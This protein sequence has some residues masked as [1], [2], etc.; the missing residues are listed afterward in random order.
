MLP[1]IALGPSKF[2]R[3][4][5]ANFP[6]LGYTLCTVQSVRGKGE[7]DRKTREVGGISFCAGKTL[8]A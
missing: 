2:H 6:V 5:D 8:A 4:A 3:L 1:A 7:G